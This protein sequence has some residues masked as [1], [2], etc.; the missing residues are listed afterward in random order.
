MIETRPVYEQVLEVCLQELAEEAFHAGDPFPSE[1]E[2]AARHGVSRA[3]ANKVLARLR[4]IG[5]LEHRRGIGCFVAERPSVFASLRQ[6]ESFTSFAESHGMTPST[7]VLAFERSA[8]VD[9]GIRE[10]LHLSASAKVVRIQRLRLLNDEP[11]IV[12][13]RFLPAKKYPRLKASDVD[14][15]FYQ[16]CQERYRLSLAGE[17]LSCR[18]E[19][20]P[21]ELD[22]S[23]PALCI[24]GIGFDPDNQ[25]LWTTR[26]CYRGDRFELIGSNTPADS[27]PTLRLGYRATSE[28]E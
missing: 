27:Y 21:L 15:S 23:G 20:P 6:M 8:P 14:H 26:L 28:L 2:L 1:R 3:T 16:L 13:E 5:H 7:E 9:P 25:P 24:R 11:V 10:D 19:L 22:G 18:P 4:G 17:Q 12:E